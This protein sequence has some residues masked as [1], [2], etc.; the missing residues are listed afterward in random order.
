MSYIWEISCDRPLKL[1]KF[2][3]PF[4]NAFRSTAKAEAEVKKR[5]STVRS[6]DTSLRF[7]FFWLFMLCISSKSIP[8]IE[9]K[10]KAA[11]P[12]QILAA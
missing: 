9:A 1:K 11:I 12:G 10:L 5:H 2:A 6:I 8:K 4:I 3:H 7:N